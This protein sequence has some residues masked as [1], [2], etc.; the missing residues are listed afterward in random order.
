VLFLTLSVLL[1]E[2]FSVLS[3]FSLTLQFAVQT[4][5]LRAVGNII[6]GDNTQTQIMIQQGVLAP[7]V[8]LLYS[9][10]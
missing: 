1:I 3:Q 8:V 7:L 4:A 2:L 6:T 9:H 10:N 5:A